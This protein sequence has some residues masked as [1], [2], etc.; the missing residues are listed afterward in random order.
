MR[1]L[2]LLEEVGTGGLEGCLCLCSD[3]GFWGISRKSAMGFVAGG[4]GRVVAT[5][6][7]FAVVGGGI[8]PGGGTGEK[9]FIVPVVVPVAGA[10]PVE[11]PCPRT[12]GGP[13]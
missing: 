2:P 3:S 6:S 4:G 8:V 5:G 1:P 12:G 7:G 10:L 13:L 9:G 11:P